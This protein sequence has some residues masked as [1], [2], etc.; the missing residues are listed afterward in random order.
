[1]HIEHAILCYIQIM[2]VNLVKRG[3]N[4]IMPHHKTP[5]FP[6]TGGGERQVVALGD[7]ESI[8]RIEAGVPVF[9]FNSIFSKGKAPSWT[10]DTVSMARVENCLV[11]NEL[12]VAGMFVIDALEEAASSYAKNRD[13]ADDSTS[14]SYFTTVIVF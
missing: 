6:D 7:S 14:I 5:E 9:N 3:M 13:R 2:V 1:M 12:T 10:Q 11:L 4:W 8:S